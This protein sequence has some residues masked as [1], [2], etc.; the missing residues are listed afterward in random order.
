MGTKITHP[1]CGKSWNQHGNRT[2]HCSNCHETFEGLSLFDWHQTL[3]DDGSV[4]CRDPRKPEFASKGLRLSDG[5]WR[6]PEW[7]G[8]FKDAEHDQSVHDA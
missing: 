5:T 4:N 2:G 1:T 3:A 7:A 6:G 8:I